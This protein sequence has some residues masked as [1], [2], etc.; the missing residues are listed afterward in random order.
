MLDKNNREYLK[1]IIHYV[2]NIPLEG[3]ENIE[4]KNSE[5]IVNHKKD[6]KMI[7]D[8]IVDIQNKTIN[9]EMNK[10]YYEGLFF[11]NDAYLEKIVAGFYNDGEDYYGRTSIIQINFD[12]FN[13]FKQ[14]K[15]IYKFVYKD[16]CGVE[17]PENPI[18]YHI[19][20]DYIYKKCYNKPVVNLSKF[21]RYCLLLKAETKEFA[22]NIAGD[23]KIMKK[24]SEKL[25][26]LNSDEKMIGLYDAEKEAEKVKRTIEKGAEQRGFDRG[27]NE[28][29]AQTQVEIAQSMLNKNLDVNLIKELT[30]LT[31]EEISSL[32]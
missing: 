19:D 18:K 13:Y 17:F 9:I 12:N 32:K 27:K 5:H 16:E 30:G 29:I 4:I 8:I 24:V 23:D 1:E 31:I 3:L 26:E 28:G 25:K 2:T 6:K 14:N 11:K 20:L 21:E 15:E 10:D 22:D 7:S